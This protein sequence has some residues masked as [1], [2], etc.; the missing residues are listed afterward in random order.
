MRKLVGV[1]FYLRKTGE[2]IPFRKGNFPGEM[3]MCVQVFSKYTQYLYRHLYF[4][5]VCAFNGNCL[6]D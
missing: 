1:M 3:L 6:Y 2:Y 4:C 5:C